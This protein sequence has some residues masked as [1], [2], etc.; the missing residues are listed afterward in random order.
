MEATVRLAPGTRFGT[1]TV[2]GLAD[3]VLSA[4]PGIVRHRCEC[5]SPHGIIAELANTELPHVL[6]HVAL[7]LMVLAGSP[8][9]IEGETR[10]DFSAD[11][12]GVFRVTLDYDDDLVALSAL[13][14]AAAIVNLLVGQPGVSIDAHSA[15]ARVQGTRRRAHSGSGAPVRP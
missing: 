10:W 14:E 11:G 7:E 15:I 6:E 9:G 12:H 1:A 8:R 2:P 13:C 4:F 5:G 3:R